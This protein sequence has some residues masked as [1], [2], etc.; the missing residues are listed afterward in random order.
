MGEDSLPG[1]C[2]RDWV[3]VFCCSSLRWEFYWK[4]VREVPLEAVGNRQGRQGLRFH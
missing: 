3:E 4:V 2:F 1:I